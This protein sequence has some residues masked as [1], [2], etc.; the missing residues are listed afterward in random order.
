MAFTPGAFTQV[1][2]IAGLASVA[3]W[4]VDE[5]VF[6]LADAS[7]ERN[8]LEWGTFGAFLIGLLFMSK[9]TQHMSSLKGKLSRKSAAQSGERSGQKRTGANRQ[10]TPRLEKSSMDESSSF[11]K[12]AEV[13]EIVRACQSG[14]LSGA[15][16][17]LRDLLRRGVSPERSAGIDVASAAHSII[18][19]RLAAGHAVEASGWMHDLLTAGVPV[20][21]RSVHAVM[22]ALLSEDAGE[23]TRRQAEGILVAA[24]SAAATPDASCF[25]CLF[26]RCLPPSDALG[27][28]VWLQRAVDRGDAV[29]AFVG[30]IRSKSQTQAYQQAET[31]L[32]RAVQAG[33]S[34]LLSVHNAV[35]QVCIRTGNVDRAKHWLETMERQAE[36]GGGPAPNS[37]SYSLLVAACA[38]RGD[39]SYVDRC[40]AAMLRAGRGSQS[41]SYSAVVK[42]LARAGDPGAARRYLDEAQGRGLVL[43][44]E[45]LSALV[46]AAAK[47]GTASVAEGLLGRMLRQGLEPDAATYNAVVLAHA[48]SQEGD[49]RG[50][51]RVLQLM[52]DRQIEPTVATL[53]AAV[54]ACARVGDREGAEAIF[55]RVVDTGKVS[56][57]AVCYNALINAYVKAG[58]VAGAERRLDAMI[59]EGVE[60]SVVSY[61]TVLHAYARS[62]LVE[63]AER[64]MKRM[65]AGGVAPNVV[66]YSALV[67]A[68]VKLGDIPRAERWFQEMRSVGLKANAV[69][70]GTLLD[71]CAKAGDWTRAERWL[72][73]MEEDDVTPTVVCFNN[74][75]NAC[76]KASQP[77]RAEAWLRRLLKQPTAVPVG[78]DPKIIVPPEITPTRQSFTT[79]AQA[80]ATTGSC[81]DVE[82]IFADMQEF[83][84]ALDEFSLTVLLSAYSRVRPRRRDRARY[85]FE[86]YVK[87]GGKITQ[88]PL[89]ALR[90]CL[91]VQQCTALLADFGLQQVLDR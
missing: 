91:G 1:V 43:E 17:M 7:N 34:N 52:L 42:M 33:V 49:S 47:A 31:W 70:Y 66:S 4:A 67:Q 40:V 78:E 77:L 55:Q 22:D 5:F 30:L 10:P 90:S 74:V 60:P 24:V 15:R 83:G 73:A 76:T 75:I 88:P 54:H 9:R 81:G 37:L 45:A 6:E 18:E 72:A 51:G 26:E 65:R 82:R 12:S 80:Y 50:P 87:G 39:A 44:L 58:D 27:V 59:A 62:G 28:E 38:E 84:M 79:A 48:R 25:H 36:E 89:R 20:A 85:V 64:G 41:A 68:C 3:L 71:V 63:A 21:G 32:S 53:A 35:I 13:Y 69:C 23:A 46:A 56:P 57:D 16:E 86:E 29:E 61:T 8:L 14:D 2:A 19:A 11:F